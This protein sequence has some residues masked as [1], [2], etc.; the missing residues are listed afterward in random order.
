MRNHIIKTWKQLPHTHQIKQEMTVWRFVEAVEH[1]F[2]GGKIESDEKKI[3]SAQE[4]ILAY[5]DISKS[6][7]AG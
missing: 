4:T 5:P 6:L 1:L 2:A 7:L 3:F